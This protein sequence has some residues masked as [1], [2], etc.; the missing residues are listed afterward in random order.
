VQDGTAPPVTTTDGVGVRG[1]AWLSCV[2]ESEA[3]VASSGA[4]LGTL[5]DW[6]ICV[7]PPLLLHNALPVAGWGRGCLGL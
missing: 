4:E 5:L 7:R 1:A 3:L 6:R 2:L